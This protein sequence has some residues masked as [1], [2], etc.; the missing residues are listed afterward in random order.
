VSEGRLPPTRSRDYLAQRRSRRVDLRCSEEEYAVLA[1]AARSAGLTPT[2][3]VA[4]AALACARGAQPPR[5]EPW[6]GALIEVMAART[7]VSHVRAV[8]EEALQL[9]NQP[10]HEMQVADW[11]EVLASTRRAVGR[12]D[13]GASALAGWL[14]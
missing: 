12:L 14:R 9:L 4:E 8:I 11:V 1:E 3:Y 13:E 2:G 10:G 6:R 5:P 7:Q